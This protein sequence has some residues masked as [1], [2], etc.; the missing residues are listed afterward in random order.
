MF[1]GVNSRLLNYRRIAVIQ[2]SM[3]SPG[4]CD[5]INV[6]S[7]TDSSLSTPAKMLFMKGTHHAAR[8]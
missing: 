8:M 4:F 2:S 5:I 3:R 7:G 1:V 6:I